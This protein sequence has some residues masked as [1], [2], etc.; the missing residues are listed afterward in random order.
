MISSTKPNKLKEI[1]IKAL[2][3]I[4]VTVFWLLVWEVASRLV[5]KDNE[6]MLLILPG[7]KAVFDK[8]LK[9]AFTKP[10]LDAVGKS[11]VRIMT[12]FLIGVGAGVVLGVL[13]HWSKVFDLFLSPAVKVIRAVP[14]IAISILLLLFFKSDNL[15]VCVVC[16]MVTPIIWQTVYDGLANPLKN[17][18]EMADVFNLSKTK[19]FL[20]IKVPSV[21]PALISS[22]VSAL[23]LA[24]KSGVA[25]EVI[26]L[27]KKSLGTMLWRS[28]GNVDFDEVC[29]ITLTIVI[30]SIVIEFVLKKIVELA[31]KKAGGEK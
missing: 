27:P 6:L 25:A 3:V 2:K 17:L 5:S 21:L 24:W 18:S 9:I 30:L 31:L 15:P 4:A 10:Y 26:S 28:K 1:L 13:T 20:Y 11:L 19:R 16:L 12:G 22:C 29:A 7:P 8:W 14:V 23:G